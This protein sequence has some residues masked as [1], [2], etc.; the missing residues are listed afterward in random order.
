M[1]VLFLYFLRVWCCFLMLVC[2]LECFF[3]FFSFSFMSLMLF[4]HVS[5]FSKLSFCFICCQC[6]RIAFSEY[7]LLP[8]F[9]CLFFP[10]VLFLFWILIV[11][12]FFLSFFLFQSVYRKRCMCFPLFLVVVECFLHVIFF[13]FS[14]SSLC[15][16]LFSS[17][18]CSLCSDSLS[19]SPWF[20]KTCFK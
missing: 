19:R 20:Q 17:P 11:G 14:V 4:S 12:F 9:S 3:F 6:F 15:V 10:G 13:L 7:S 8:A 1:W 5:F 2:T 18:A 16:F